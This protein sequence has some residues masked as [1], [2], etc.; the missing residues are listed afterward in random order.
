MKLLLSLYFVMMLCSPSLPADRAQPAGLQGVVYDSGKQPLAGVSL[1][2]K[3]GKMTLVTVSDLQ[4][5][6]VFPETEAGRYKL[7]AFLGDRFGEWKGLDLAG[8]RQKE[9]D[10]VISR[11]AKSL[12]VTL[13]LIP[14]QELSKTQEMVFSR[15]PEEELD[16]TLLQRADIESALRALSQGSYELVLS[17][18]GAVYVGA[19]SVSQGHVLHT[20]GM[21]VAGNDFLEAISDQ[22]TL[23]KGEKAKL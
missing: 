20:S 19:F 21:A 15:D 6:Y 7:S 2:L 18:P 3:N 17:S 9:L 8:E 1:Y 12:P 13:K 11:R 22:A 16:F 5:R 14:Q 10:L 4:G 23:N